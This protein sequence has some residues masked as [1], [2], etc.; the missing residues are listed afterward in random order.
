MFAFAIILMD[1]NS[2][3]ADDKPNQ[4]NISA[5]KDLM[6]AQLLFPQKR[7]WDT[8]IKAMVL[9]Q[10]QEKELIASYDSP[11]A[12]AFR[13]AIN[14]YLAGKTE[15]EFLDKSAI[16]KPDN[17]NSIGL[18]VFNNEYYKGKFLI[19]TFQTTNLG[20]LEIYL[21]SQAN[22]DRVLVALMHNIGTDTKEKYKLISFYNSTYTENEVH[23]IRNQFVKYIKD[24]K[25][26]F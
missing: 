22:P 17:N 9:S 19:L 5:E 1:C 13:N 8:T 15:S 25:F 20:D 11:P 23:Q 16:G 12:K 21:I 2:K 4:G 24:P 18:S 26:C 14:D 6:I 3:T 10:E 7:L